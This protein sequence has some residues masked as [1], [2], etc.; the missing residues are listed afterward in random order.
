L[1]SQS[2]SQSQWGA[3]TCTATVAG[4]K[5]LGPRNIH[6]MSENN[7]EQSQNYNPQVIKEQMSWVFGFHMYSLKY[8]YSFHRNMIKDCNDTCIFLNIS[9]LKTEVVK[10]LLQHNAWKGFAEKYSQH[11]YKKHYL[12]EIRRHLVV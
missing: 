9:H 4:P 7:T 1:V 5:F 2:W 6:L 12:N 10:W 3:T 11:L 8:V